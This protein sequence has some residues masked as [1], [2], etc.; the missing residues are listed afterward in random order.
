MKNYTSPNGSSH[1]GS[2]KSRIA[3]PGNRRCSGS[4]CARC[5]LSGWLGCNAARNHPRPWGQNNRHQ[6][7]QSPLLTFILLIKM[8]LNVHE[9]SHGYHEQRSQYSVSPF[10]GFSIILMNCHCLLRATWFLYVR[11]S[12]RDCGRNICKS[13]QPIKV[14]PVP[15]GP[16]INV[17]RH[18]SACCAALSWLSSQVVAFA[19]GPFESFAAR[20]LA[21]QVK[22]EMVGKEKPS[23]L[24]VFPITYCQ[25]W[26]GAEQL[27]RT[28]SQATLS[29][30]T[31]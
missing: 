28:V 21:P 16:W 24:R 9:S 7:I 20:A 5:A 29:L 1:K 11:T 25:F 15:G 4:Q 23:I 22:V 2:S 19:Q 17:T 27:P 13:L 30:Q 8:H 14:F 3:V 10:Q 6:S 31:P 12:T 18:W 26:T